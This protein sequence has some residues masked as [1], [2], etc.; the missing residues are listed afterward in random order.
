SLS[1]RETDFCLISLPFEAVESHTGGLS[2]LERASS[3]GPRRERPV[4]P[5]RY[6]CGTR[7]GPDVHHWRRA[8]GTPAPAGAGA[9]RSSAGSRMPAA[10]AS[11]TARRVAP[12][13][14]GKNQSPPSPAG[15]I[16]NAL[17]LACLRAFSRRGALAGCAEVPGTA[18]PPG[19][20][21]WGGGVGV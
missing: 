18:A 1:L 19:G 9:R 5:N 7:S 16:A 3:N 17:W 15:R 6:E 21:G 2:A 13:T 4:S 8:G 14:A 10:A 12:P 11:S 20:I